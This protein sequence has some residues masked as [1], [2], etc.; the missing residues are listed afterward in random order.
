MRDV[1]HMRALAKERVAERLNVA[2]TG[3]VMLFMAGAPL[4]LSQTPV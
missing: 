3:E 1:Q 4:G 2:A